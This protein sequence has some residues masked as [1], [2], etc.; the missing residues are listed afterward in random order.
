M[1]NNDFEVVAKFKYGK[2]G[3]YK[4]EFLNIKKDGILI[5]L[6]GQETLELQETLKGKREKLESECRED[7]YFPESVLVWNKSKK[8]HE[9][10]EN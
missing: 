5:E 8:N 10:C 7:S 9:N 6:N 3:K 1:K 4:A 2:N